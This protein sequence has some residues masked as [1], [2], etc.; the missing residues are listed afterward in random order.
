MA[1]WVPGACRTS[2]A[3]ARV[4]SDV[5]AITYAGIGDEAG[6]SLP[7]QLEALRQL[8]WP[9]IELRTVDG[10]AIADIDRAAFRQLARRTSS[11]GLKVA[12][13]ASRIGDWSRPITGDFD[14]DLD[15]LAVLVRRCAVLGAGFIRVMSY[16]AAGLDDSEWK[17]R[18][19]VRLRVLADRAERA[20]VVLLHENCTG[21]AATRPE[22]ML[23]LLDR[24]DSPALR[25]LF[26]TG[27]GIAY[28]YN[29]PDMLAEILGHVAHV[30]IKDARPGVDGPTYTEPGAGTAGVV[31]CLDMLLQ[32][33]YTGVWSIEPHLVRVHHLDARPSASTAGDRERAATFVSYGRALE[34]LVVEQVL[35]SHP[36]WSATTG[37]LGTRLQQER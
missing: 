26:D 20:G 11:S 27:N 28:G 5:A 37:G 9:T 35:P 4:R 21:W 16:C 25:L 30:H 32:G 3:V 17:R 8:G 34:R 14:Q 22:R 24:V 2:S 10:V 19:I 15:E 29:G 12:C 36:A 6:T 23:E 33:G 7:V 13:L 18:S 31:E 1:Q